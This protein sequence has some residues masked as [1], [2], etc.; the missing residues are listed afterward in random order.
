MKEYLVVFAVHG[1]SRREGSRTQVFS[2][3]DEV[4]AKTRARNIGI[5]LTD[6]SNCGEAYVAE[7]LYQITKRLF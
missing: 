1:E 4:E 5:A 6:R 3:S 7:E 2:A